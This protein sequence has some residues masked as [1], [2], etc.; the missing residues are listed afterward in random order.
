[1]VTRLKK[2]GLHFDHRT[3]DSDDPIE[4]VIRIEMGS[5]ENQY[6]VDILAGIRGCPPGIFE[7]VHAVELQGLLIP[8]ASPEDTVILKLLGGSARDLEDALS[9]LRIQGNRLSLPLIRDLCPEKTK[10]TLNRLIALL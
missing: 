1:L 8:V 3:G 5:A 6:E 2:A 7:R 4:S 10:E 9:I